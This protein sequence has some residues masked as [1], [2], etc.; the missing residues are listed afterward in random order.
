MKK[1]QIVLIHVLYW[2]YITFQSLF[3]IIQPVGKDELSAKEFSLWM[4]VNFVSFYLF[5]ATL[6]YFFRQKK[7]LISILICV[8]IISFISLAKDLIFLVFYKY[9]ILENNTTEPIVLS[10]KS[11]LFQLRGSVVN[12][13]YA[14][15]IF[16]LIDWIKSLKQKAEL[17]TQNQ[18]SEL[19]LLRSQV[20]PHFLFNTLNNI[21]SLIFLDKEKASASVIKLSEI[22]RYMIYE[23]SDEKVLLSKEIEY[24]ESYISLQR[25][26]LK[27]QD[28]IVFK[29]DGSTDKKMIAPMLFIPF[30]ENAFKHGLKQ[31]PSPGIIINLKIEENEISFV[32]TNYFEKNDTNKKD[33]TSGIGLVNV[34]R[35]LE[36]IY[37]KKHDL[38]IT[39]ENGEYTINLKIQL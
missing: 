23:T 7:K 11:Y 30:V 3:L 31:L 39:K 5:Y 35:R 33:R 17:I 21:D 1:R 16:V 24:L 15:F 9:G 29:V 27:N 2:F 38:E 37:P 18:A 36:L 22:M 6:P 20:S 19:A 12:G 4:L 14:V 32:S 26:R 34:K 8:V 25:L 10:L 28:Y 13:I